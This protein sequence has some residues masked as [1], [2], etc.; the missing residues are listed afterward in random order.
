[1]VRDGG[2]PPSERRLCAVLEGPYLTSAHAAYRDA[3]ASA[4]EFLREVK[5]LWTS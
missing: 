1:M 4:P 2:P 5:R 3:V